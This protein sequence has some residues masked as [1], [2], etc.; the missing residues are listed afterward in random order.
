MQLFF[1]LCCR[2]NREQIRD[3]Q[4]DRDRPAEIRRRE[5]QGRRRLGVQDLSR[6]GIM[7]KQKTKITLFYFSI[8]HTVRYNMAA[9]ANMKH[10]HH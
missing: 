7:K 9:R 8:K 3:W 5:P 10:M 1:S 2:D 6:D 4:K